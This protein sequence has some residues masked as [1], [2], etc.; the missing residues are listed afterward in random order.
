LKF[1]SINRNSKHIIIPDAGA[2][3]GDDADAG[4]S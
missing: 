4:V 1:L 2:D 3:A